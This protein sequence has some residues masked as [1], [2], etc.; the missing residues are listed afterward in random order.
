MNENTITSQDIVDL[1]GFTVDHTRE[2][3]LAY[4]YPA[5]SCT[6]SVYFN[7]NTPVVYLEDT[8]GNHIWLGRVTEIGQLKDVISQVDS[9]FDI[10]N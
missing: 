9:L 5:D 2:D 6:I 7:R 3:G 4:V 8:L 10:L 1:G